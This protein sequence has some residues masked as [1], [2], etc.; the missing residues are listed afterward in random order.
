MLKVISVFE[1]DLHLVRAVLKFA[2]RMCGAQSVMTHG[3]QWMLQW[4][5]GSWDLS[6]EVKYACRV[7]ITVLRRMLLV[8]FSTRNEY[9]RVVF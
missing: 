3:V 8:N 7:V 6:A 5:A 9:Q 1:V 2:T 4:L